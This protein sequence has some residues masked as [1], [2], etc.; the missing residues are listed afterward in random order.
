MLALL[1]VARG[2]T[3]LIEQPGGSLMEYYEKLVWLFDRVP[4]SRNLRGRRS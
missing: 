4:A 1:C 3:F 2:G